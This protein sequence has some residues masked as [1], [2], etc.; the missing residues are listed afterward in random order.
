[1]DLNLE[2]LA[3]IEVFGYICKSPLMFAQF[4]QM[5]TDEKNQH[6]LYN[7]KINDLANPKIKDLEETVKDRERYLETNAKIFVLP[8]P[9]D[10]AY[11]SYLAYK[12]VKGL[13]DLYRS[14]T[15]PTTQ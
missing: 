12:G 14:R 7:L 3:M 11:V 2:T 6:R 10:I 5:Y 4:E 8:T 1:M 15:K 9:L 13:I